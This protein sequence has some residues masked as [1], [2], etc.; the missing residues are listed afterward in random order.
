MGPWKT[1][2]NLKS[3]KGSFQHKQRQGEVHLFDLI[4]IE[5]QVIVVPCDK[6][7]CW[8]MCYMSLDRHGCKLQPH[9]C[10][11]AFNHRVVIVVKYEL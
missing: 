4:N 8:Y 6:D 2:T 3:L 11:E 1:M 9:W 7:L 5:L 10:T